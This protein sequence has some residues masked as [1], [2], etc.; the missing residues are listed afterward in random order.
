MLNVAAA[1]EI[2]LGLPRTIAG[3]V[4][5]CKRLVRTCN[6]LAQVDPDP[7]WIEV[8]VIQVVP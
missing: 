6:L 5:Y 7:L 4:S 3:R 1:L 8:V 2:D